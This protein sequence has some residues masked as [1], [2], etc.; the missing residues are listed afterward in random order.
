MLP[1]LALRH[2]LALVPSKTLLAT[3]S[4]YHQ[5]FVN[6]TLLHHLRALHSIIISTG[7]S[8]IR[9]RP[10]QRGPALWSNDRHIQPWHTG[11]GGPSENDDPSINEALNDNNLEPHH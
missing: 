3:A 11:R 1:Q 10:S 8:H 5:R 4:F 9:S 7:A 6:A 2:L